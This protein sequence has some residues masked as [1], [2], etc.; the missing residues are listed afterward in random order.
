MATTLQTIATRRPIKAAEILL[1]RYKK[2]ALIDAS[3]ICQL[4]DCNTEEF[5][6][7]NKPVTIDSLSRHLS[8]LDTNV[9][10]IKIKFYGGP[11]GYGTWHH[12]SVYTFIL[13]HIANQILTVGYK[14]IQTKLFI[15]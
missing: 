3:W 10:D 12:G 9:M 6:W 13:D 11:L 15:N 7:Q 8:L 2:L 14:A 5:L 1:S 4:L